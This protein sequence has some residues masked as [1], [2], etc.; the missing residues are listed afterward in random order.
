MVCPD[1]AS[2]ATD[3]LRPQTQYAR[4]GAGYLGGRF[5]V[6]AGNAY[7]L[8]GSRRMLWAYNRDVRAFPW[9]RLDGDRDDRWKDRQRA[10]HG[11][12]LQAAVRGVR[13]RLRL[14]QDHHRPGIRFSKSTSFH[15]SRVRE[16]S[17]G[18]GSLSPQGSPPRAHL[19]SKLPSHGPPDQPTACKQRLACTGLEGAGIY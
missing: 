6:S 2:Q 1:S 16:L 12:Y 10:R 7:P 14:E 11:R 18:R 17:R 8:Y 15:L 13:L 5:Q 4:S 3:L 19:T 9:R